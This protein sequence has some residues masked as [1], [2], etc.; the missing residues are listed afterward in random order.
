MKNNTIK[1]INATINNFVY[2]ISAKSLLLLG[3]GLSALG[4]FGYVLTWQRAWAVIGAQ[5]TV[6]V[7]T[8][9]LLAIVFQAAVKKYQSYNAPEYTKI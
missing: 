6:V 9:T 2:G 8:I 4:W 3:A 5:W 7:M 1:V